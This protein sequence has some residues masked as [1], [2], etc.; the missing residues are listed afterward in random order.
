[1]TQ[2]LALLRHYGAVPSQV[3]V[4]AD[5]RWQHGAQRLLGHFSK[6]QTRWFDGDHLQQAQQWLSPS[7]P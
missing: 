2:H 1:V 6:A 5:K 4:I 7:L 3:A